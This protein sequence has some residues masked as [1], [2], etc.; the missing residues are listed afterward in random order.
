MVM[1]KDRVYVDTSVIG[2][3]YDEEFAEWS[4]AVVASARQ[5]KILLL[6]SDLLAEE[7]QEA[8]EKIRRL[9]PSIPES[10][11]ALVH[12]N[13]ETNA[14]LRAYMKEK[15]VGRRYTTDAHH[16]ALA[17]VHRADVLLSWNFKHIVHLDKIRKF[18]AMNIKLGYP[19]IEIRSPKEYV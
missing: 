6:V 4:E 1:K 14:L 11:Q 19:P 10:N 12:V 5:G 16:V 13:D 3:C 17:T 7:L 8:P 15:I 9:L 18:N 2:G